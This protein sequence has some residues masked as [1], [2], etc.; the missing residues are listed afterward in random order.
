MSR[1]VPGPQEGKG[2]I[3]ASAE[4]SPL[5]THAHA[6]LTRAGRLRLVHRHLHDGIP[7]ASVAVEFRVSRPAAATWVARYR[8]EASQDVRRLGFVGPAIDLMIIRDAVARQP[9]PRGTGDSVSAPA[10]PG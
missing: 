8:S 3:H 10:P 6:P 9:Q 4:G 1:A 7:P 2:D 5:V